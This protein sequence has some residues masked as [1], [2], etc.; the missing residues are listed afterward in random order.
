MSTTIYD[1]EDRA[2]SSY[3]PAPSGEFGSDRKPTSTYLAQVPHTDTAYDQGISGPAVAWYNTRLVTTSDGSTTPTLY[4]APKLHATG[5]LPSDPTWMGRNL[6]SNPAPIGVDSGN[7]NIGF[8]ATGKI[9]FPGSGT[10]T[11]KYWH[12]DGARLYIDDTSLFPD[13]DW[14][15]VGETQITSTGTFTAVAGQ[16]YRFRL[17]FANRNAQFQSEAWLAGPGITDSSGTGLGTNHWGSYVRADYSLQTSATSY[18]STVGNSQSTTG[19]GSNPEL[20]LAQSTTIDPSGQNL[21]TSRTY[22]AAGTSGSYLRQ[23]SKTLPGGNTTSYSYYA[24]GDT[25]DNPCTTG[26]E[27]FL[28]AGML[29]IKTEPDPDGAGVQ[30]ARTTETIYDDAGRVVATR[31]NSDGWTCTTYDARG[32]TLTTAIPAVTLSGHA[33]A[34]RTIT[35]NYAV[36]GNPLVTA[37]TD[38]EG[39][40]STAVDLLGRTASYT[41]VYGDTTSTSYDSLGRLTGRT[42]P[43][44]TEAYVYDNL[45]R[46]TDQKLDGTIYAH[47][48]YD[49]YSRMASVTYPAAGSQQLTISRDVLGRT[50]G[51]SYT[52]GNGTTGPADAVTRSQ[53][54]NVVSGTENG[55]SKSYTYDTAGRLTAATIGSSTY[56]YGYG[57]E[58]STCNSLSGNNTN[59]GRNSNRTTQ[60]VNGTTATFCYDQADKLISSSDAT[61]NTPTYDVHGNMSKIGTGA[62][63]LRLY[64]DSSDRNTGMEQYDP[65]T[66]GIGTYYDRDVQGRIVARYNNTITAG[67][68]VDSGDYYYDFTG[69]GDTPDYVRDNSWAVT[70]KYLSLPGGTLLTIRPQQSGNGQKTYSLPNVHGDAFATTNAAGSLLT[71]TLTGPFGEKISGQGSAN[72]TSAG[73]TFGYEGEHEKMTESQYNL[74][75]TEM[76]ARVYLASVGR[77]ASIDPVEGGNANSYVYPADPVNQNDLSGMSALSWPSSL[78]LNIRTHRPEP[79]PIYINKVVWDGQTL[80]I[81]PTPLGRKAVN[82]GRLAWSQV[83]AL[84]P[85]AN[86]NNMKDQFLCHWYFVRIRNND[87][88]SWNLD[89]YRPDVGLWPTA[90]QRCNPN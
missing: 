53:S 10:Y 62:T 75:P 8:S 44:G 20:G 41:D 69:S 22:E 7:D 60:T 83:I 79:T 34:A 76:G 63:P 51:Q 64:Y 86:R 6:V 27:S 23:L 73:A 78:T 42:S 31:V 3:G 80:R 58:S 49:A 21:T 35:N 25:K 24:A 36:G 5:I 89:S 55:A 2:V 72:N 65:N 39:T 61:L 1:D 50:N 68:W 84:A 17:D 32:R 11:F 74:F 19:Y 9:V 43:L 18:D 56:S 90:I 38:T 14:S 66:T 16:V 47:V 54:G 45:N 52:L 33:Q 85:T 12:D 67:S 15:H 29:H 88:A 59:A 26:T 4:G 48:N 46:L 13:S 37:S 82:F 40:I 77:F 71:T 81:Y 57:T 70:E 30:T 28:Q 87:K